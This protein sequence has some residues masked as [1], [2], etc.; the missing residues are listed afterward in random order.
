LDS[1]IVTSNLPIKQKTFR[2][3]EDERE[4]FRGTTSIR[5]GLAL[6]THPRPSS[7]LRCNG[8][9]RAGLLKSQDYFC[10]IH[11]KRHSMVV[12]EGGFQPM[13]SPSLAAKQPPT[14]PGK[15]AMQLCTDY[16]HNPRLRQSFLILD[17]NS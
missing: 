9:T 1:A 4:S 11:S 13:A 17:P 10:G 3:V 16:I 8:L 5:K 6:R 2:P 7:G 12:A 15:L 14:L